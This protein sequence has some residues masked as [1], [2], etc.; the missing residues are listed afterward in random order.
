VKINEELLERKVVLCGG[1]ASSYM[2][3]TQEEDFY[4]TFCS[5]SILVQPVSYTNGTVDSFPGDKW[6]QCE[7]DHPPH[8]TLTLP[9]GDI[10]SN[11]PYLLHGVMLNLGNWTTL[12][13]HFPPISFIYQPVCDKY[14]DGG[15]CKM[16]IQSKN[17]PVLL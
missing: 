10:T 9:H 14:R 3:I 2:S 12:P 13:L 7:A 17:F 4:L 8:T 6:L 1:G 11:V 16:R 15:P 5:F